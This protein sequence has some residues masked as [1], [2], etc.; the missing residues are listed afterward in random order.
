MH[1]LSKLFMY[2]KHGTK[3]RKHVNKRRRYTLILIANRLWDCDGKIFRVARSVNLDQEKP[4]KVLS[5]FFRNSIL[6]PNLI[7]RKK[8]AY[9]RRHKNTKLMLQNDELTSP[10]HL[11]TSS[12]S[13]SL[14]SL[15]KEVAS[16]IL[17]ELDVDSISV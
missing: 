1:V 8:S 14:A 17:A 15:P 7:N 9:K 5:I 12:F 3:R 13:L 6:D 2:L 11:M 10:L 4:A 16:S